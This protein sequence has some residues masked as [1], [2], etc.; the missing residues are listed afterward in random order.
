[1][2]VF[3]SLINHEATHCMSPRTSLLLTKVLPAGLR[4]LSCPPDGFAGTVKPVL[5]IC[6]EDVAWHGCPGLSSPALRVARHPLGILSPVADT[7]T[8]V[9][10]RI[11]SSAVAIQECL[12]AVLVCKSAHTA[13]L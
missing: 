13:N 7:G 11:A 5:Q 9:L 8:G 6:A 4:S 12:D 2:Q 1:M 3:F 10:T